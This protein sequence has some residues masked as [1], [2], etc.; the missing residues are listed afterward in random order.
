MAYVGV[1]VCMHQIMYTYA[2]MAMCTTHANIQH[3]INDTTLLTIV[4]LVAH[5][6]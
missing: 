4:S 3:T 2:Q 5:T 1:L 6:E